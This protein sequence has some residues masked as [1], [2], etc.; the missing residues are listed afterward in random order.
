MKNQ[1]KDIKS[2]SIEDE[3][4]CILLKRRDQTRIAGKQR[5]DSKNLEKGE[6]DPNVV[7]I[8]ST[9]KEILPYSALSQF[10]QEMCFKLIQ[11]PVFGCLVLETVGTK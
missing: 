6:D 8:T 2:E 5:I 11:N 3:Y 7:Y 10:E 4:T 9:E 1:F